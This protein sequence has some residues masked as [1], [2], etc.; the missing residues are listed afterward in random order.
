M[1]FTNFYP[2]TDFNE[3]NLD[4]ILSKV[5]E[6]DDFFSTNYPELYKRLEEDEFRIEK[7]EKWI[8]DFDIYLIEDALAKYF[9][10][11]IFLEISDAGY[12]IYNI[13]EA[14]DDIQ[15]NTT[16][17]DIDVPNVDYGHLTLSY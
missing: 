10:V 16:G 15:F 4:W 12:I 1:G 11:A 3:L 7:I 9:Q 2:Y 5:K 13:P 14:W 8:Q 6:L 17:L